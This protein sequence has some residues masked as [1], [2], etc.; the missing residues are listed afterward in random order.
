MRNLL[1]IAILLLTTS[2]AFAQTPKLGRDLEGISPTG[3]VDVIIQYDHF[4]TQGDHQK[5]FHQG[6]VLKGQYRNVR[7]ALYTVPASALAQ[8]AKNPQVTF[9]S[10]NRKVHGT[11]DNTAAAV[12]A[13]VAWQQ[14]L[15]GTG[16]GVAI[17]DSGITEVND[18]ATKGVS[19]VVYSQDFVGTGTDDFYGHGTHVAGI[20]AGSGAD[21]ICTTCTRT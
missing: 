7:S 18:L 4:P 15:D 2:V 21:S 12:N 1:R 3:T 16:I 8:L 6:G 19:R 13:A 20:V 10:P 9:I 5:V 11:L 17:I 14:N